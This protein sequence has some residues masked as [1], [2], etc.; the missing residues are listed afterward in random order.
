MNLARQLPDHSI[1]PSEFCRQSSP[2]KA[3]L[4]AVCAFNMFGGGS[5][6]SSQASTSQ[7]VAASEGSL[8]V[9]AGGKFL[10]GGA[11][12]IS[13]SSGADLGTK[14]NAGENITINSEDVLKAAIEGANQQSKAVV[15]ALRD[16]SLTSTS[17]FS[18]FAKQLE[19]QKSSDLSTALAAIGDLKQTTD[20]AAQQRKTFLYLVLGV[21]T[22]LGVLFFP[23]NRVK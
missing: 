13:G 11:I 17:A 1:L 18:S 5:S 20:E 16:Q 8:A 9:G 10:E 6:K 21:L 2:A 15:E 4:D 3:I 12:D 7:Q 19:D 22:L 23:W 14:L